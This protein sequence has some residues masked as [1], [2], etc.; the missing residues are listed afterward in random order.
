M[1]STPDNEAFNNAER[2]RARAS[3]R[4]TIP[5]WE[6]S[7][8]NGRKGEKLQGRLHFAKRW[9]LAAPLTVRIAAGDRLYA[10][11]ENK[12]AAVAIPP[13]GGAPAI[14]WEA[15]VDGYPV[16]VIAASGRLFVTTDR[17]ALY[18]FG[19][20]TSEPRRDGF[21]PSTPQQSEDDGSI[22]TRDVG[23]RSTWTAESHPSL[24]M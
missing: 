22:L 16:G 12:I 8:D 21:Q 23:A 7:V 13:A 5:S 17:G 15:K 24:A 10:S 6:I 11:G 2:I 20:E 14:A 3:S 1:P 19:A 9:E 4:P 18:C